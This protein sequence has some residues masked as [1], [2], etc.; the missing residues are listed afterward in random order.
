M[1][2][3][4]LEALTARRHDVVIIG[5]G[6]TGSC[7]A[8]DAAMRGLSV[9]LVEARD[10]SHATSS[11]TTKLVH[12]GLRYLRTLDFALVRESLAERRHWQ[13][14]APHMVTPVP[15]LLPVHGTDR[16]TLD[17]GLT[18]YDIL[19]FDRNRLPE[20]RPHMAGHRRLARAEMLE[21]E[22]VLDGLGV[23]GALLYYD[24]Q[25]Y[26]P[27]RLGLECLIDA[28]A[29][30]ALVAN[31]AEA[32]ACTTEGQVHA[33]TVRDALGGGTQIIRGRTIV[34]AA[35]PWADGVTARLLGHPNGPAL[36]RSKG[37]HIIT[38]ALTRNHA[39]A[40]IT[41]NSHL[42]VIPWRGFSLIGTTDTPF[43]GD[44]AHVALEPGE[45]DA[46]LATANRA[47]PR[48]RLTRG[49][50]VHAYAGLRPLISDSRAH[51]T[52]GASR[53]SAIVDHGALGGPRG[54]YSALGGKWTTARHVAAE[55]VDRL[56]VALGEPHRPATTAATLL[57]GARFEAASALDATLAGQAPSIPPA[58]RELLVHHYGAL[59]PEVAACV[60]EVPALAAQLAPDRAE[61]AAQVAYAVDAEM[62]QTLED[63]VF[64]RTGLGTAG[65]HDPEALDRAAAV[66]APR[67]GW[68]AAEIARQIA[69]TEARF[70]VRWSRPE[71]PAR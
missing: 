24:C 68:G 41:G 15:F 43:D 1:M 11:A 59:A 69:I 28:T 3:R 6:I 35:G 46:L 70:P 36:T 17:L 67:L 40:L 62:A 13:I 14:I 22:P 63:V 19:S 64:R 20:G 71:S 18:L 53:R 61:I 8:R 45:I 9:A 33:L 26:A 4:N 39:L 48:A 27:E 58:S 50:V 66:M 29:H 57:P 5:G 21:T 44:P 52:Y 60:T 2:I 7:V 54:L 34:N 25:M 37:I 10:F 51:S 23:R 55:M 38:R 30:G 16:V 32:E 56:L 47:L 12:G 49:D 31:Y 42:F 65:L